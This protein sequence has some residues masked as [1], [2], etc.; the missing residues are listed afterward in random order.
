MLNWLSG[1]LHSVN[2]IIATEDV[3]FKQFYRLSILNMLENY[4]EAEQPQFRILTINSS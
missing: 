4:M 2:L 3:W 1:Q